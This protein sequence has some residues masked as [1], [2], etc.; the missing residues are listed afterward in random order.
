MLFLKGSVRG[1]A[2][3][4]EAICFVHISNLQSACSIATGDVNFV[5]IRWLTPHRLAWERDALL[6]PVCPGPFHVNNC[7]WK[8]AVTPNARTAIV[9]NDGR[10]TPD[11][12]KHRHL[13]GDTHRQQHACWE[14]EKH[15]YY[16]LITPDSV[17]DT[18]NMCNTFV[19]GTAEPDHC[20]WMQTITLDL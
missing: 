13:F 16:G 11:W 14:R 19:P 7:L 3:G 9:S 2:L 6:R 10:P 1:N 20:C 12:V 18:M 17:Q 5:L 8:Y 15:A 4:A